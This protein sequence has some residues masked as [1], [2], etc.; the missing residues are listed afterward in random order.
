MTAKKI[1]LFP[2]VLDDPDTLY[3]EELYLTEDE[4]ESEVMFF[5]MEIDPHTHVHTYE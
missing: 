1:N 2:V 3:P 5:M 4:E